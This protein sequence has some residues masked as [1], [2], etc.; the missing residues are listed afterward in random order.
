MVTGLHSERDMARAASAVAHAAVLLVLAA[1]MSSIA[2]CAGTA[3]V[4][5]TGPSPT[6]LTLTIHVAARTSETPIEGALIRHL[7]TGAYTNELG[8][9]RISVEAGQETTVE[10]SAAGYRAMTASA[11]L[12]SDERWTFFLE[13]DPSR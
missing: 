12:N 10:A 9:L 7:A 13:L 4:V 6:A 1:G 11:V 5:P 3:T 2:A 8:E